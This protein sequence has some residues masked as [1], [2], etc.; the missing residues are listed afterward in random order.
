VRT[1]PTALNRQNVR[2]ARLSLNQRDRAPDVAGPC[3]DPS[4]GR[5]ATR[6]VSR[7][8]GTSRMGSDS[9]CAKRLI[10]P[11]TH[12]PVCGLATGSYLEGDR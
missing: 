7:P 8:G 12:P 6:R 1:E 5:T 10:T 11:G 9:I 2:D 4:D 3:G